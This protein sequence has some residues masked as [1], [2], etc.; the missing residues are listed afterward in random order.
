M[1]NLDRRSFLKGS[2]S[3]TAYAV[4]R[5]HGTAGQ[6]VGSSYTVVWGMAKAYRETTVTRD[7]ICVDGLW[8]RRQRGA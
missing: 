1:S 6:A 4:L 7:R 3:S 5:P 2:L 8:R